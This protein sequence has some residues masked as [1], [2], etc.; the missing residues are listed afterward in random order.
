MTSTF[1]FS[2][3]VFYAIKGLKLNCPTFSCVVYRCYQF[4]R[5]L[6]LVVWEWVN[7]LQIKVLHWIKLKAHAENKIN[8]T[9]GPSL[10]ESGVNLLP[11]DKY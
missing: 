5:S 8:Q 3:N 11:N 4:Q 6:K 2:Y 1:S 9:K 10:S 7:S